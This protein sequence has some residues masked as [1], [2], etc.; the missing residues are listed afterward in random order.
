[1]DLQKKL[2]SESQV[3]RK[4]GVFGDTLRLNLSV[5]E[6][7][8]ISCESPKISTSVYQI[9]ISSVL[10]GFQSTLAYRDSA[11]TAG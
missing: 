5:K 6:D 3:M 9:L 1:M 10:C 11:N 7:K 8:L 4:G 2:E